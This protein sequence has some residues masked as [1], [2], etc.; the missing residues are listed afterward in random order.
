M[1]TSQQCRESVQGCLVLGPQSWAVSLGSMCT[2]YTLATESSF[3]LQLTGLI[4]DSR[5]HLCGGKVTYTGY[6][7]RLRFKNKIVVQLLSHV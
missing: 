6:Q 2:H 3:F 4:S 1:G 5:K 7:V